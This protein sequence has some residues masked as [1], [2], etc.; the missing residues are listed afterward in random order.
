MIDSLIRIPNFLLFGFAESLLW[1]TAL[2]GYQ[3]SSDLF[4]L[5]R[6]KKK[7]SPKRKLDSRKRGH[8]SSLKNHHPVGEAW[9]VEIVCGGGVGSQEVR[10]YGGDF[11][12]GEA[13]GNG[14]GMGFW[15]LIFCRFL[16]IDF[17]YPIPQ[18]LCTF[19]LSLL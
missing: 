3:S 8:P 7:V 9:V 16:F 1:F 2:L 10:G 12:W 19:D 18:P 14:G 5:R 13:C 11:G 4:L 17:I 6:Q 15:L